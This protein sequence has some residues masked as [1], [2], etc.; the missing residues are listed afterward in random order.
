MNVTV[1][2]CFDGILIPDQEVEVAF[3]GLVSHGTPDT[4]WQPGDPAEFE[5][6]KSY[7]VVK[8]VITKEEIEIP[9]DLF[10]KVYPELLEKAL[11]AS[12]DFLKSLSYDEDDDYDDELWGNDDD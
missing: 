4:Y 11:E 12:E 1:C 5:V 8:G 9:D 6:Q 2:L 7:R 3:E 10:D